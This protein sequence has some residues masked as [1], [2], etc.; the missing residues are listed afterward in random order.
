MKK[1][2]NALLGA[3][4]VCALAG[5]VS[6]ATKQQQTAERQAL[7]QKQKADREVERASA[8]LATATATTAAAAAN[9]AQKKNEQQQADEALQAILCPPA[10]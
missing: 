5:C 10:E 6:D 8:A 9:L 2:S 4:L 1:L 3:A 7:Q